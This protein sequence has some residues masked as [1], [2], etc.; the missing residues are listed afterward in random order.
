MVSKNFHILRSAIHPKVT[1]INQTNRMRSLL[2]TLALLV[3]ATA[4]AQLSRAFTQEFAC[5]VGMADKFAIFIVEDVDVPEGVVQEF[6][7]KVWNA[8]INMIATI[9]G[10]SS[11]FT[12][13]EPGMYIVAPFAEDT[14][15]AHGTHIVM[16]EDYIDWFVKRGSQE[17]VM[18]TDGLVVNSSMHWV[19]NERPTLCQ[20]VWE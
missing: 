18:V 14:V 10:D 2:T 8:K 17:D 5:R 11:I 12:F 16:N 6:D 7:E 20:A 4:S 9:P 19:G 3:T 15:M 1:K 13:T